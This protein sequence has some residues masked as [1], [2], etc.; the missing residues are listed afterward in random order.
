MMNRGRVWVA[1]VGLALVFGTSGA[2]AQDKSAF[3][4]VDVARAQ[5]MIDVFTKENETL[6]AEAQRLRK[7]AADLTVQ[8]TEAQKGAADLVPLWNSLKARYSELATIDADIVD[9]GLKA[10]STAATEKAQA[11][12]KRLKR[13]IDDLGV[14]VFDLGKD[15]DSRLAQVSVDEARVVRNTD[16]IIVLQGAIARTKAQQGRLEAVIGELDSLSTQAET[17][18]K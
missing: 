7:E 4:F 6:S 16:D 2:F 17:T 13:R 3:P 15:I 14:K 12:L 9:K 11:L 1:C 10:E 18:L 8:A 5:A